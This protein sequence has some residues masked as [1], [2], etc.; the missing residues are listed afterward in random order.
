MFLLAPKERTVTGRIYWI[1]RLNAALTRGVEFALFAAMNWSRELISVKHVGPRP[2]LLKTLANSV[3]NV[4]QAWTRRPD[5]APHAASPPEV[6][7]VRFGS[8]QS[9]MMW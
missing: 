9:E 7:P 2:L 4:G 3:L 6:V 5:F 8:S 1:R